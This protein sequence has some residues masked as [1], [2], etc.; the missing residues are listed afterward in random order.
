MFI[1]QVYN[2]PGRNINVI[3]GGGR[4]KFLPKESTD[5][6]G[7]EGERADGKN[8]I[9]EWAKGK[10]KS[11]VLFNKTDL[12]K[13]DIENTEYALGL[14]ASSHL[15]FNLNADRTKQP[16][17][18]EMTEAAIKILQ[19]NK[20]GFYLFVEGECVWNGK[21]AS[22]NRKIRTNLSNTKFPKVD[23]SIMLIILPKPCWHW[24][25]Q[26]DFQMP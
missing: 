20:N 7:Y 12:Q 19:K 23:A 17:L 10:P 18:R 6:D 1:R 24:M 5:V 16:S 13:M 22:V 26:L 3:F 14:F 9:D 8:L 25:K 21:K 11:I 2:H 4:T 15:D